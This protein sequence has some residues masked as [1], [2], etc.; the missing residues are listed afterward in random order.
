M[1]I[2]KIME[3]ESALKEIDNMKNK[4]CE[5]DL[6]AICE[7]ETRVIGG[8]EIIYKRFVQA[9]MCGLVYW[10]EE[11]NCLV[12]KLINPLKSGELTREQL[13]YKHKITLGQMKTFKSDTSLEYGIE[14]LSTITSV[15]KVLIGQLSGQDQQIATACVDFFS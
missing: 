14:S 9:V 8:N 5:V 7:E 6:D 10:D 12:Q 4:I 13:E 15:P 2:E 3:K 1:T 11:K